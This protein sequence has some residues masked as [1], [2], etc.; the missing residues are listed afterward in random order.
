MRSSISL[1]KKCTNTVPARVFS[2]WCIMVYNNNVIF[3]LI[4]AVRHTKKIRTEE[5]VCPKSLLRTQASKKTSRVLVSESLSMRK[6]RKDNYQ[7]LANY[8]VVGAQLFMTALSKPVARPKGLYP[9]WYSLFS[10]HKLKILAK[11]NSQA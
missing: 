8:D 1:D 7:K 6:G 2:I 11:K 4:G 9:F 5:V 3:S 10:K